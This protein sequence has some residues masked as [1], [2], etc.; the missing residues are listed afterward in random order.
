MAHACRRIDRWK[1]IGVRL[2]I[3]DFGTGTSVL[4]R[5][6]TC[7]VDTLKIDRSFVQAITDAAPDSPLVKALIALAHSLELTVVAEGAE[8]PVQGGALRRYG[9]ELIQGFLFSAAVPAEEIGRLLASQPS[10]PS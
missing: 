5:L 6:Q 9:C 4:T 2:A 1:G 10:R 7:H 8:T 3:D